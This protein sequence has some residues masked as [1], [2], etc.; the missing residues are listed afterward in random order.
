VK[1]SLAVKGMNFMGLILWID[2]NLFASGLVEKVFKKKGLPFYTLGSVRDFAYLVEDLKPVV[3]VLDQATAM[4][5][6]QELRSQYE[7]SPAIQKTNFIAL[8][9]WAGLEFI[10]N[11]KGLLPRSFNPFDLPEELRKIIASSLN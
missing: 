8:E 1:G 9:S 5:N 2:Q 11:Q 10:Q 4:E 7:N 6:I 3:I